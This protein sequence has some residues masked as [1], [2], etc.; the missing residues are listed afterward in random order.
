M[1]VSALDEQGLRICIEVEETGRKRTVW[2]AGNPE[3][4]KEYISKDGRIVMQLY[5]WRVIDPRRDN[6]E[7]YGEK[8]MKPC[9]FCGAPATLSNFFHR[10]SGKTVYYGRCINCMAQGGHS[11]TAEEARENWNIRQNVGE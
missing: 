11:Y 3:E 5:G 2:Y 4:R 9:P 10:N 1:I 7:G 6:K 8:D